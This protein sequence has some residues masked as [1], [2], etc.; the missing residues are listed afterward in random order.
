MP[1]S[2]SSISDLLSLSSAPSLSRR[3]QETIQTFPGG[4]TFPPLT[5]ASPNLSAT[6]SPGTSD[7]IEV[8]Q[9]S[10]TLQRLTATDQSTPPAPQVS[11][12]SQTDQ[13]TQSQSPGEMD[14]ND[15]DDH[16]EKLAREIYWIFQQRMQMELERSGGDY[17]GRLAW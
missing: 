4:Q 3:T 9:T 1:D 5:Y 6:P 8:G 17:S 15:E 13:G 16:L 7:L 2:W 11:V 10:S 12:S 14:P